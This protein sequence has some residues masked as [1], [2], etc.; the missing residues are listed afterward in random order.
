M[1]NKQ[2][3]VTRDYIYDVQSLVYLADT[4]FQICDSLYK[5]LRQQDL[6][7]YNQFALIT[8]NNAFDCSVII[9]RSLIESTDD[10]EF[11]IEPVI[12]SVLAESGIQACDFELSDKARTY[13]EKI[14][15]T[16]PQQDYDYLISLQTTDLPSGD[17]VKNLK[18]EI[19]EK[20]SRTDLDKLKSKFKEKGFHK[21]RH[22]VSAHK[23]KDVRY[24]TE[25][26][27]SWLNPRHV[28]DLGEIVKDTRILSYFLCGYDLFN[29][30][31]R[32]CVF[33]IPK[34]LML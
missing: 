4:N 25:T 17:V 28:T 34:S 29:S 19:V 7:D 11:R 26:N 16:Y 5:K 22:L 24:V 1:M 30:G 3:S 27:S 33:S 12:D 21:I 2:A 10:K 6:V 31:A 15:Q 14:T 13:K 23:N 8:A 32:E 18:N 20:C 9:L